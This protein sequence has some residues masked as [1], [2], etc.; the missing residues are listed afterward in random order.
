VLQRY[1]HWHNQVDSRPGRLWEDR[2]KSV[3]VEDGVEAKWLAYI[4]LNPVRA[5]LVKDL[6]NYRSSSHSEAIGGGPK[7]NGKTVRASLVQA[8]RV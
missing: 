5:G 1:T 8:L 7:G 4:D 3:I 6:A 2:F